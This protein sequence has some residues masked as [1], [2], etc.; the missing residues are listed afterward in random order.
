MNHEYPQNCIA[1]VCEKIVR[2]DAMLACPQAS[3]TPTNRFYNFPKSYIASVCEKIVRRDAMLASPK[4]PLHTSIDLQLSKRCQISMATVQ[5]TNE[6]KLM[7][8]TTD[9]TSCYAP[10]RRARLARAPIGHKCFLLV[11]TITASLFD[12][13]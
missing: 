3:F 1:S 9:L 6:E 11:P 12:W 13:Q 10:S 4:H 2:R 8:F 7:V 5:P